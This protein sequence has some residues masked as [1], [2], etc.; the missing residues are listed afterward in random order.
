MSQQSNNPARPKGGIYSKPRRKPTSLYRKL[1]RKFSTTLLRKPVLWL[2]HHGFRPE[3]VFLGSY[4]RSGTT[5]SRFVLYEIL[6]GQ[7]GGFDD[8]NGL[9]HGVGTQASSPEAAASSLP[10]RVIGR[11]TTRRFTWYAMPAM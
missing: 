9:L 11:T 8:V 4:P 7:E 2:R 5:W 10:T 6:T 3:D 1:R